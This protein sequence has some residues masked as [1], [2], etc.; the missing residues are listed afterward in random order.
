MDSIAV[1]W[2]LT[3][4]VAAALIY[5]FANGY[6][7][8]GGGIAS[9]VSTGVL[10][11]SAAV[12]WTSGSAVVG[13]LLYGSAVAAT[14][15]GGLIDPLRI[16]LRTL[17]VSLVTAGAWLA[18]MRFAALPTSAAHAMLG[19]LV[20]AVAAQA[21]TDAV[22]S[23]HLAALTVLLLVAPLLA[24]ALSVLLALGA[25][26][27]LA[28]ARTRRVERWARPGQLLSCGLAA[29]GRGA[30]DVQRV[31]GV[32][33]LALM[34]AAVSGERPLPPLPMWTVWSCA[35]AFG[36]GTLLGGWQLVLWSRD[37]ISRL[38]PMDGLAAESASAITLACASVIGAPVST[39]H[40]TMGGVFGAGAVRGRH[41]PWSSLRVV[42]I[43]AWGLTL[44]A[45]AVLGALLSLPIR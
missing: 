16:D 13:S 27:L 9:V 17:L 32:I 11:P 10:R 19:A 23:G 28:G 42:A 24:F 3:A 33:W 44:P 22:R 45:T 39:A 35:A 6:Q 37:K 4:V 31:A 30:N 1:A 8:A 43:W 38:R 7:E 5:A 25:T 20:G 36:I 40:V 21:G 34:V 41:L 12:L 14:L 29:M 15:A 26:W 2:W 18:A